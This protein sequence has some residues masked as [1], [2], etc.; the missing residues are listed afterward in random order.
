MTFNLEFFANQR[1]KI[2]KLLSENQIE[3]KEE[4]YIALSQQE[5]ADMAH[6]SKYKTNRIINELIKEDCLCVY[7]NKRGKYALTP[8]GLKVLEL[9]QKTHN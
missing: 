2:L 7:N 8:K 4:S 3:V 9:I 1:Y 6:I 5:I